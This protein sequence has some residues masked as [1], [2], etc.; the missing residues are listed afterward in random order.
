[1]HKKWL[2]NIALLCA[3][4]LFCALFFE[5]ALRLIGIGYPYF[6]KVD[7]YLGFSPRP[8]AQ[9]W[10]SNEGEAFI[11]I[12][13]QGYRGKEY[14]LEKPDETYRV[15]LLGDSFAEALQVKE[16][17]RFSAIVE[18]ELSSSYKALNE[19]EVEVINLGVSGYSTAQEYLMLKHKGWN[20]DPDAVLL[21]FFPGNDVHENTS[22]LTTKRDRPFFTLSTENTLL[23]DASFR[24]TDF[25]KKQTSLP[26]R[27]MHVFVNH[28]RIAQVLNH[29]RLA[30]RTKED[31]QNKPQIG[32]GLYVN[33]FSIPDTPELT[34]AW[35]V[36]NA[37]IQEMKKESEE[38][39]SLFGVF[40]VSIAFQVDPDIEHQQERMLELGVTDSLYTDKLISR[41]DVPF[42]ALTTYLQEV[43]QHDQI[44]IHGFENTELGT[45][46]W[47]ELGHRI[48]GERISAFLCELLAKES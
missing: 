23:L 31:V 32:K 8:N 48:A 21:A 47:N 29:T 16:E 26:A 39:D 7:P 25:F 19:K 46:H 45:G 35:D 40:S 5:I 10:K 3:T 4:L 37:L 6:T 42:L 9:G 34:S 36:T 24:E 18:K 27:M 22:R 38:H 28:S 2:A 11:Q 14:P 20:L 41:L 13:S 1:M 12:N 33:V 43:S 17:E 44:Y 30:L 15:V